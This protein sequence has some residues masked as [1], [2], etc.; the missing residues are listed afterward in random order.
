M[1]ASQSFV[2]LYAAH[3]ITVT[4]GGLLFRDE[5]GR[6]CWIDFSACRDRWLQNRPDPLDWERHCVGWR[7][8]G[9]SPLPDVEFL[10]YP[11]VR[12]EFV[13]YAQR[14]ALLLEPMR[15]FGWHTWQDTLGQLP[16]F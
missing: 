8:T 12:F 11:R 15:R 10:S 3:L 14:N 1:P 7:S 13:G 2:S 4:A 16:S 5:A 6:V 9:R